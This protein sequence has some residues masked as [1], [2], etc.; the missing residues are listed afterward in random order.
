MSTIDGSTPRRTAPAGAGSPSTN[1][2][3]PYRLTPRLALRL[4]ILGVLTILVFG[5][6]VLRLWALQVLQGTQYLRTAQNNQLRSLPV[7]APRGPILDRNGTPLVTNTAATAVELWPADLPKRYSDRYYELR[8]LA[9]VLHVPLYEIV[10][11]APEPSDRYTTEPTPAADRNAGR[12]LFVLTSS[13]T[14]AAAE[15]VAYLLPERHRAEVVGEV[16]AG[17]ANP[18]R[19]YPLND[20][21]S[22]NVPNGRV[23]SAIGGGNWEGSGVTPDVATNAADALP[24][25][26][27]RA[28][29][30]L[31]E[32]RAGGCVA[33]FAGARAEEHG[34]LTVA[35]IR[36]VRLEDAAG[37]TQLSCV[38]G[39]AVPVRLSVSGRAAAA[40]GIGR[41]GAR[42]SREVR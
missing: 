9:G 25:A 30:L 14:F 6:L 33:G 29:R 8:R 22:V 12:P 11:R 41:P 26:H 35:V 32:R 16:T 38:A 5:A 27:A 23:K 19:P 13:R 2:D 42:R 10:H 1:I 20:R 7:Q 34:G 24:T 28:L 18:G 3:E 21:F 36:R 4:A 37:T 15:G 39:S 40:I 17:T 31:I